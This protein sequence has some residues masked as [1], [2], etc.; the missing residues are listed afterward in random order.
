MHTCKPTNNAKLQL[1]SQLL[2]EKVYKIADFVLSL[3][4]NHQR[5]AKLDATRNGLELPT[6]CNVVTH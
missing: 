5:K 1:F 2:S 3:Q 4:M 6:N